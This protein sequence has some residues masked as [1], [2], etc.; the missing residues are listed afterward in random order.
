MSTENFTD[1][2]DIEKNKG[3]ETE[4]LTTFALDDDDE[5]EIEDDGD[6]SDD[7]SVEHRQTIRKMFLNAEKGDENYNIHDQLPSVEEVKASNAYLPTARLLAKGHRRKMLLIVLGAA[8]AAIVLSVTISVGVFH[9]ENKNKNN[10]KKQNRIPQATP[11]TDSNTY[12]KDRFEE[13]STFVFDHHVSTLPNLRN[14]KSPEF[15]AAQFLAGGD[16]YNATI[17][18]YFSDEGRRLVERYV[19][20]LFYY[21]T[22]GVHWDDDYN[23]LHPIDHCKWHSKYTTPQ[24]TF[25]KG[26]VCDENGFVTSMDVSNNNVKADFVPYEVNSLQGLTSLH[27]F[28]NPISGVFP[29]LYDLKELKSLGLMNTD[30]AGTLPHSIGDMTQLTTLALGRTKISSTIPRSIRQLKNLR[31]LGLDGLGLTGPIEPVLGLEKLEALY[32]EDNQLSG[33]LVASNWKAMKELDISN[34]N[35]AGTIPNQIIQNKNLKVLDLHSNDFWGSFPREIFANDA[36]E[37]FAI[38]NNR[39]MGTITDRIGYLKNL[40]HFDVSSNLLTGTIPDTISLLTKLVSLHTSGNTFDRQPMRNFF[41]ALSNL[42][43]MSMKGNS[44][45]GTIP[46]YIM[47]M[48]NLELLDLDGNELKGT[49]STFIGILKNLQHLML[50]RNMLSGTIPSEIAKL[51]KLKTV[52][53]DGNNLSG[54]TNEICQSNQNLQHFITDC[55]PSM[56]ME[57]GPEVDC[58]CCTM[59]CNDEA[60]SCNDKD[61]TSSYDPSYAYGYIRPAY[62]FSLDQA[63][64]EWQNKAKQESAALPPGA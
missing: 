40:K 2:N 56:N 14:T 59:C 22:S 3:V 33:D 63:Q 64:P 19:L 38:Q 16:A 21:Q 29:D 17:G 50:N 57:T 55:F 18:T 54:K 31:I 20:A 42:K 37:Y 30:I 15:R 62:D 27:L 32:L 25:I 26:I 46:D 34:N 48:H 39:F 7:D 28:G 13:I 4:G 23:F 58:R 12:V 5:C 52:L 36:M 8:F 11:V 51:P 53:L 24:G 43:E 45:T 60:L 41:S 61:W 1:E 47:N 49:I 9:S 10:Q 6:D 35:I 44:F